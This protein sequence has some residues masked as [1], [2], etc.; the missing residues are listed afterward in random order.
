MKVSI[1]ICLSDAF[2]EASCQIH[3]MMPYLKI[4]IIKNYYYSR[5]IL[6]TVTKWEKMFWIMFGIFSHTTNNFILRI[7]VEKFHF[8]VSFESQVTEDRK[9]SQLHSSQFSQNVQHLLQLYY[10][11]PVIL[12]QVLAEKVFAHVNWLTTDLKGNNNYFIFA[13]CRHYLANQDVLMAEVSAIQFRR[14]TRRIFYFNANLIARFCH[15]HLF[16]VAFNW[17]YGAECHNLLMLIDIEKHRRP[18]FTPSFVLAASGVPF[19]NWPASTET[20]HTIGFLAL[21][22]CWGKIRNLHGKMAKCSFSWRRLSAN[23]FLNK[24]S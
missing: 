21:K 14:L 7:F 24:N 12:C 4:S 11:L 18:K 10:E 5:N 17:R 3:L 8:N 1:L 13:F 15:F 9:Q 22:I 2:W 20:P 16:M 19:F 6:V 23:S